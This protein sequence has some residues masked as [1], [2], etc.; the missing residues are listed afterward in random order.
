[1][2]QLMLR[3]KNSQSGMT[4]VELMVA[5]VI[6]SIVV[7]FLFSIQTRMSRAYQGQGTVAEI[8]QNLQ[9]AKQQLVTDIRMAGF[10]FGGTGDVG[11][12]T[13]LEDDATSPLLSAGFLVSNNAYLDGNDSFRVMYADPII[14]I[15]IDNIPNSRVFVDTVEP[16]EPFED[17]EPVILMSRSA[18]CL[19]AV[20]GTNPNK[21]LINP[22]GAPY[23]QAPKNKHCDDL[24]AAYDAGEPVSITRFVA[25]SYRIDPNR[26]L[27]GYL[28]MSPS[29]EV[30][31]DDWID[32]GV[33]FTNL[34]IATRYFE[35]GDATDRDGDGDPERDWYSSG[36][37]VAGDPSRPGN[38][39]L[40]QASISIEARSPFGTRG[41]AA[42]STTPAFTDLANVNNNSRGDWGQAC[43]GAATNPCGLHLSVTPDGSRTAPLFNRYVGEF[44]Y[45]STSSIVDLRNMGIGQ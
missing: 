16:A 24:W 15:L 44:I 7:F 3:K 4:L 12:S 19:V 38:A 39:V 2:S 32:I 22:S 13:A 23:N 45:R 9:A 33:G 35:P 30:T 1:M 21:V 25:R 41:S 10:G 40:I 36:N 43:P 5:M 31:A 42:S 28:Q 20:T 34:Q 17:D 37:Q 26:P 11:V 8:N 18:A 6:S 14:D 27:E 29:G